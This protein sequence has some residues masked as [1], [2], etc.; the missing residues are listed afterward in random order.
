LNIEL[1][2]TPS[3]YIPVITCI[4]VEKTKELLQNITQKETKYR[5]LGI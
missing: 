2:Q 5:F 3:K 4:H 1:L